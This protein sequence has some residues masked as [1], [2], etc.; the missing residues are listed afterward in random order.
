L[1]ADLVV[2]IPFSASRIGGL[3]VVKCGEN[4]STLL[5]VVSLE[6]GKTKTSSIVGFTLI[7]D[8]NT[9]LVGIEGPSVRAGQTYLVIPIPRGTT[10]ISRLGTVE[11]RE[12]T[13]SVLQI[14]S[15]V[16]SEA[17]SVTFNGLA[18]VTDGHTNSLIVEDPVP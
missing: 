5:E 12:D 17:E 2:P 7:T 4:A 15:L 3:S 13:S 16:A 6:A 10:S 1:K 8:G 11:F 14:I 18:I 9:Y